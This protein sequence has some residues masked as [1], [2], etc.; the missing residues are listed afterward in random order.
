MGF[1]DGSDNKESACKA[2]DL[3]LIPG[4]RRSWSKKQ[5]EMFLL[6]NF[7]LILS[8]RGKKKIYIYIYT[9]THIYTWN[10]YFS[11]WRGVIAL[12]DKWKGLRKGL[13]QKN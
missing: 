7:S 12:L 1:P 4:L 11:K 6:L 8:T 2:E 13:H 10:R 5:N 3:G 9:H